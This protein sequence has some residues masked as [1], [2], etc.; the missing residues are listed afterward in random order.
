[1]GNGQLINVSDVTE[2][3]TNERLKE[4]EN[5]KNFLIVLDR[6]WEKKSKGITSTK[7]Q[8]YIEEI[9]KN[10]R[11]FKLEA[12]HSSKDVL[13]FFQDIIFDKVDLDK[14]Q[15]FFMNVII[16]NLKD[17][18]PCYILSSLMFFTEYGK[19]PEKIYDNLYDL[20]LLFQNKEYNEKIDK[21]YL[22]IKKFDSIYLKNIIYF[23]IKLLSFYSVESVENENIIIFQKYIKQYKRYY[24]NYIIYKEYLETQF[25][26]I[27]NQKIYDEVQLSSFIQICKNLGIFEYNNENIR[28]RLE[29]LYH[30]NFIEEKKI[31]KN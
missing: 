15:N 8:N 25:F 11:V 2:C 18:N 27:F 21:K 31:K 24:S 3:W 10:E 20:F 4:K 28:K 7:I 17:K 1:M 29:N 14:N 22:S 19:N 6:I 5:Q 13:I 12:I 30:K 23:Y 26:E 16:R 9:K